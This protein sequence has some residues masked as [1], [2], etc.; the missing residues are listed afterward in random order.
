M[1]AG[2]RWL[3]GPRRGRWEARPAPAL[4]LPLSG[5]QN[6]AAFGESVDL[7]V[8]LGPWFWFLCGGVL[9]AF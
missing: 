6:R 4:G 3:G 5:S 7:A 2:A 1:T 8:S 9:R